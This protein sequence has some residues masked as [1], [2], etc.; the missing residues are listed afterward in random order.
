ME[1]VAKKKEIKGKK[2]ASKE[3]DQLEFKRKRVSKSRM[4]LIIT[5]F[6]RDQEMGT[7]T[8]KKGRAATDPIRERGRMELLH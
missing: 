5:P 4:I 3:K 1:E 2:A 6:K 7:N 8:L